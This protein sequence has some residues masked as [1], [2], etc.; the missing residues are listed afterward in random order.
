MYRATGFIIVRHITTG[1]TADSNFDKRSAA[2]AGGFCR[3]AMLASARHV[4][5]RKRL[6]E[7]DGETALQRRDKSLFD[8]TR[9]GRGGVTGTRKAK[10]DS[11]KCIMINEF[12]R[13]CVPTCC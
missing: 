12:V 1:T 9:I 11:S 6:L 3:R 13:A 2:C 8:V 4:R 5:L 10:A 7:D